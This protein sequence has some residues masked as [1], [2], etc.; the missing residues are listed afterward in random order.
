MPAK[1]IRELMAEYQA[2]RQRYD[3]ASTGQIAKE[4][5]RDIYLLVAN[6]SGTYAD[7]RSSEDFPKEVAHF[8][9]ILIGDAVNGHIHESFRDLASGSGRSSAVYGEREAIAT[10]VRYIQAAKLRVIGDPAPIKTVQ[11][12]FGV[13]R[14]TVQGWSRSEK[15]DL[16]AEFFPEVDADSRAEVIVSMAQRA[17]EKYSRVGRGAKAVRQRRSKALN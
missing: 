17:G 16:I 14:S 6:I 2:A 9:H 7:P 12:W 8:L 1:S 11:G 4:A 10:A 13:T 3:S 15:A 5:A